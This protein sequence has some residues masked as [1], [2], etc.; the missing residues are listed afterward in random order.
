MISVML[1][2]L[3]SACGPSAE[4]TAATMAAETGQAQQ[5]TEIIEHSIQE[6]VDAA[7]AAFTQTP[8]FTLTLTPEPTFTE[9][10]IPSPTIVPIAEVTAEE[11]IIRDGPGVEYLVLDT[12]KTGDTFEIVGRSADNSWLVIL[13]NDVQGWI[14]VSDVKVNTDISHLLVMETPPTPIYTPQERNFVW[15]TIINQLDRTI[16]I[17]FY[18]STYGKHIIIKLAKGEQITVEVPKG[19]YKVGLSDGKHPCENGGVY[20]FVQDIIWVVTDLCNHPFH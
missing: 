5:E 3:I 20:E 17:S 4:E 1:T 10:P 14:S 19:K 12:A 13:F 15:V 11:A 9:T 18:R 7:K 16:T 8:T 2:I 6:T